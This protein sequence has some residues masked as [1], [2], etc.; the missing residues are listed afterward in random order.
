M[1]MAFIFALLGSF[2]ITPALA[3]GSAMEHGKMAP[4][5]TTGSEP[6]SLSKGTLSK[7]QESLTKLGY[8]TGTTDGMWGP[9]SDV[10]L[11]AFQQDKGLVSSGKLDAQSLAALGVNPQQALTPSEK[12]PS[13]LE[14]GR[15]MLEGS[16]DTE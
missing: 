12:E 13:L 3:E 5:V 2:V 1:R 4:G 14:K 7:V 9:K 11:L 15:K 6:A 10:A 16:G 8:D